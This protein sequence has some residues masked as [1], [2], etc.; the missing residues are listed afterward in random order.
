MPTDPPSPRDLDWY[1]AQW[2]ELMEVLSVDDPEDV[3]STVRRLQEGIETLTTQH[4]MLANVDLNNPERLF[5]MIENMADQLEQLY[6][7]R[8]RRADP[9]L[10]RTES[11]PEQSDS[12]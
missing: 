8:E 4:D 3:V 12:G 7:E 1:Q 10:G 5:H 6:A 2:K 9:P 11:S